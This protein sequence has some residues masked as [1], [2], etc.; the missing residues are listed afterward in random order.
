MLVLF[1]VGRFSRPQKS[2]KIYLNQTLM[3]I[4]IQLLVSIINFHFQARCKLKCA[5]KISEWVFLTGLNLDFGYL[6]SLTPSSYMI[7]SK[8]RKWVKV[9]SNLVLLTF[10]CGRLKRLKSIVELGPPT[11]VDCPL[12]PIL[13]WIRNWKVCKLGVWFDFLGSLN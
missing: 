3:S 8:V 11:T 9:S 10:C 7:F 6:L 2:R 12:S 1:D 5:T 13:V 4:W